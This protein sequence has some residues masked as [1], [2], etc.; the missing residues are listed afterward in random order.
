VRPRKLSSTTP[1]GEGLGS[2]VYATF[3]R[4]RSPLAHQSEGTEAWQLEIANMY[5][6]FYF[7]SE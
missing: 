2:E 6:C 3:I 4:R 7:A 1:N 5:L